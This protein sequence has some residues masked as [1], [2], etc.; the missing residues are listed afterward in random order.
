[1]FKQPP[2]WRLF[3][4]SLLAQKT[5]PLI[6]RKLKMGCSAYTYCPVFEPQKKGFKKE[7]TSQKSKKNLRSAYFYGFNGKETDKETDLQDYGM[8][9]YNPSLGRFLSVDPIAA[10]YPW[11]STYAFA[12]NMPIIGPDLEGLEQP[13]NPNTTNQ[14]SSSLS[15]VALGIDPQRMQQIANRLAEEGKTRQEVV[16]HLYVQIKGAEIVQA[17]ASDPD[18]GINE[19]FVRAIIDQSISTQVT[20]WKQIPETSCGVCQPSGTKEVPATVDVSLIS[21]PDASVNPNSVSPLIGIIGDLGG[22]AIKIRFK[23]AAPIIDAYDLL[24]DGDPGAAVG[25]TTTA[26]KLGSN[27]SAT[28]AAVFTP[29]PM[30]ISTMPPPP[31]PPSSVAQEKVKQEIT[32]RLNSFFRGSATIQKMQQDN[33]SV[34][35]PAQA[36]V[37]ENTQKVT[38]ISRPR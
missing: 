35:A 19:S 26:L 30:G 9:I 4:C 12:E 7:L 21:P 22:E 24:A 13:N 14:T 6:I 36:P 32:A 28:V 5:V 37:N 33:T 31:P 1:M 38:T 20:S 27:T 17:Y 16:D 3:L 11:N 29:T 18:L 15:P 25:L 23:E 8:R 34:A 10:D 2:F